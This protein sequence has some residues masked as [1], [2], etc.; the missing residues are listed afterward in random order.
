MDETFIYV[1]DHDGNQIEV[2]IDM[3]YDGY[4]Y[5]VYISGPHQ[6]MEFML[7]NTLVKQVQQML[8]DMP[9]H[10]DDT[11]DLYDELRHAG[12]L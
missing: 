8:N 10:Y 3:F 4:H 5:G 11:D 12:G 2:D 1:D 9:Q 6:G 7:D